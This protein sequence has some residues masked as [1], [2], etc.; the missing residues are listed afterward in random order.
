MESA[1][2][3][4]INETAPNGSGV[5]AGLRRCQ[6]DR[7]VI[8]LSFTASATPGWSILRLPAYSRLSPFSA[9]LRAAR[10]LLRMVDLNPQRGWR[11][12]IYSQLKTCSSSEVA[13]MIE[14]L[15]RHDTEMEIEK[16]YVDSHG[17]SE[18][19]FGFCRLLGFQ[20]LPRLKAIHAQR[21]YRPEPGQPDA[22][23]N[24]QPVLRRPI[25]WELIR[26][27][28]DQMVKYATALRLG[29]AET[30]AILKRFTRNN[31]K[32]PT[33]LALAELGK[34]I[35]TIFLCQYLHSESLRQEI[36]EGLNV[37]ENWNGTNN[38]ILYGKGGEIASND[39]DNQENHG[40]WR[41]AAPTANQPRVH[42]YPDDPAH[43]WR[44]ELD[45]AN[46]A[47]GLTRTD[48]V[49]LYPR[50]SLW[51]V[52]PRHEQASRYR[53][54]QGYCLTSC[55]A[56]FCPGDTNVLLRPSKRQRA[57]EFCH[58]SA[59]CAGHITKLNLASSPVV[60]AP[61]FPLSMA[62]T[63]KCVKIPISSRTFGR[64]P[65]QNVSQNEEHL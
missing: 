5:L 1:H 14:G 27:Q 7:F 16:N 41:C 40:C 52:P 49:D 48:A 21:L 65:S 6:S 4:L 13:A 10:F 29:T 54:G 26:Q 36:Q 57:I 58:V 37:I 38:F 64:V 19:A 47:G 59:V 62:C 53:C 3:R 11:V 44:A 15:L 33:Y 20:L 18:V 56:L 45:A 34:A 35:K 24:L 63:R 42:Q 22:F 17:Q 8:T 25:N 51:H 61:C 60:V 28:Y 30:E 43:P 32:H 23:P 46:D 9:P 55:L 50:H 12:C 39:L 2:L 31:L